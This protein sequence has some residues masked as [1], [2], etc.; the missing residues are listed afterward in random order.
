MENTKTSAK[1]NSNDSKK[2]KELE[3]TVSDLSDFFW[4]ICE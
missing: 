4:Q 1:N 3:K 2:I